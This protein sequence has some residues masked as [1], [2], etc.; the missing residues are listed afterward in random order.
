MSEKVLKIDPQKA[1][2]IK[3]RITEEKI[4]VLIFLNGQTNIFLY[5]FKSFPHL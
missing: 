1:V 4:S 2:E 3:L 5:V